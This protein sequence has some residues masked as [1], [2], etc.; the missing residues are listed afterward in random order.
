MM[1]RFR[2]V[3]TSEAEEGMLLHEDVRDRAG[4]V[5]LPA[6]TALTA[7]TIKS[8]LRRDVE[9]LLIVDDSI[10]QEQLA[11][12]RLRVQERLAYLYRHAGGGRADA[13]VRKVVEE[14][15][16]AELQ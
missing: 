14:Y 1:K 8:L 5:L 11:V 16:M 3:P 2:V 15:R 6:L 9:M 4:N 10:T 7:A 13:L 12:E